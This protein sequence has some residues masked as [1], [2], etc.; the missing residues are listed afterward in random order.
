MLD[1]LEELEELIKARVIASRIVKLCRQA[2]CSPGV[3]ACAG[4]MM[5]AEAYAQTTTDSAEAHARAGQALV[6]A[7]R[8]EVERV[9]FRVTA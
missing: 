8:E 3:V 9:P 5:A 4:V 2:G 1:E 6:D 7:L